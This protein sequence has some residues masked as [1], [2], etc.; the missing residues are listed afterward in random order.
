M[1]LELL[2]CT[3]QRQHAFDAHLLAFE[4]QPATGDL[5]GE[6][7]TDAA[8]GQGFEGLVDGSD[9]V[10]AQVGDQAAEGRCGCC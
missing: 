6:N 1:A 8:F 4:Q 10:V 7:L 9:E 2:V 3:V 5:D